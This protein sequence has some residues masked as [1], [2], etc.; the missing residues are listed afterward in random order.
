MEIKELKDLIETQS[1][2]LND[3]FVFVVSDETSRFT[4][5]QY[6]H[7]IANILEKEI[8][9]V[10]TLSAITDT[11]IGIFNNEQ[12]NEYLYICDELDVNNS[13]LAKH[14]NCVIITGK[15]TDNTKA[16]LRTSIV[17]FPTL[18]KWQI[19][20]YT[21]SILP[22]VDKDTLRELV[23]ICNY[24]IY[25]IQTAI[26]AIHLYDADKQ[27]AVAKSLI[28]SGAFSDIC[29]VDTFTLVNAITN[30]DISTIFELYGKLQFSD[31]NDFA[32]ITLLYNNFKK[33]ISVLCASNP[34]PEQTGLT[35]KQIWAIK[36]YG[37][38]YSQQQLVKIFEFIT[39]IDKQIKTGELD[40][41]NLLD[42]IIVKILSI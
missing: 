13:D 7:S 27:S 14:K 28:Q 26:D 42:Y 20:D 11:P 36:K 9:Q 15:L 10:D 6:Y 12:E 19:E 1:S 24:N 35:D 16:Y 32:V 30:R 17:V 25:R 38:K 21:Y 8:L 31:I 41:K 18:E 34:T 33:N 22:A 3:F 39:A 2:M 23:T 37:N 40:I 4:A 29:N 5:F